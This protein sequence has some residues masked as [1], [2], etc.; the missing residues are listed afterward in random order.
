MHLSR[1]HE[2]SMATAESIFQ[3]FIIINFSSTSSRNSHSSS[4]V[5]VVGGVCTSW[6]L[7]WF[8]DTPLLHPLTQIKQRPKHTLHYIVKYSWLSVP[9]CA[10]LMQNLPTASSTIYNPVLSLCLTPT[11]RHLSSIYN[12]VLS[13][14]LTP[15]PL[16]NI[17]SSGTSVL[18]QCCSILTLYYHT[19]PRVSSKDGITTTQAATSNGITILMSPC[20]SLTCWESSDRGRQL[21][22]CS[23]VSR[24]L[25]QD[26]PLE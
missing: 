8:T 2:I 1:G 4:R 25:Q 12:P 13:L 20:I 9:N 22:Y 21:W 16:T 11:Q 24:A 10:Q 6:P 15:Y 3:W 7:L 23:L 5:V 18:V 14:C 26:E 17:V 19:I